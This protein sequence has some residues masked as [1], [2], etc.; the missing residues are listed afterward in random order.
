MAKKLYYLCQWGKNKETA[1][2]GTYMKLFKELGKR[3]EVEDYD[4]PSNYFSRLRQ[5]LCRRFPFVTYT[6]MYEDIKRFEKT[7]FKDIGDKKICTFQFVE[8]KCPDNIHSYIYQDMCVEYFEDRILKDPSLKKYLPY[9][10]I[11]SVVLN[12]RK[13]RQREYYSKCKGIFTMS[14]WLRDYLVDVMKVDSKKV[15]CVGAG[16]DIDVSYIN[17]HDRQGNKLLFIGRDFVRKGG[18]LVVSAFK[19]LKD[20]YMPDA[21]L[22]IIGPYKRP[23]GCEGEGIRFVG[24]LGVSELSEYYNTCDAFVMPSYIE[25]FGKVFVES[26]SCGLP[27]IGRNSFAMKDIIDDG[28]NGFL[29]DDDDLLNLSDKMFKVLTDEN[30]RKYTLEHMKDYQEKY[31][32]KAVA[33]RICEVLDKD[34]YYNP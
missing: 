8:T 14:L 1:W 21:E 27:C 18:D 11:S 16:I 4:I 12:K 26:L 19:I 20:K 15:H 6:F 9:S 3:F 10:R 17:P 24:P 34:E 5:G 31:T 30:I 25:A 28:V 13:M 22:I 7:R 23:V 32:W 2:S 33:D 29:I